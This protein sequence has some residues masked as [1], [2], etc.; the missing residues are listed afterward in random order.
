MALFG[1]REACAICGGKVKG[2][3]PWKVEGQLVCNECHGVV[4]V[5][6]DLVNNLNMSQFR[7][8]MAFRDENNALKEH[9]RTTCEVNTGFF[10]TTFVFDTNNRLMCLDPNLQKTV[11]KGNEIVS[12]SIREDS[13][14]IFEG[15]ANGLL[16]YPSTVPER[17]NAMMPQI[18]QIVMQKNLERTMRSMADNDR[19]RS[20]NNPP[21]RR[22]I[23]LPE[24][25][26]KFYIDIRFDHPYWGTLCV[27]KG[28]PTFNNEYPDVHDYLRQ[29]NDAAR[30][31]ERLAMALMAVAFP[32]AGEQV[33]VP[34]TVINT[35]PAAPAAPAANIDA[36]AE[37][38]RYKQLLDQGIITQEDFTAKK[39]QLLGI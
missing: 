13:T 23:D 22:Y 6:D 29:Y 8:Y 37:I 3:F 15:S 36:V 26:A 5:P 34:G 4:D 33:V 14:P 24:P 25:F 30:D 28:G 35:A 10:G 11:F 38:Q 21:P 31:M 27:E 2:L 20:G 12:F 9:F 18:T 16:R 32:N 39:R 7:A 1:K 19:G 17:A